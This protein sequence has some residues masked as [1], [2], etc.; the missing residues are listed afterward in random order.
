MQK[1]GAQII[2]NVKAVLLPYF[3]RSERTFLQ[4]YNEQVSIPRGGECFIESRKDLNIL[5][6]GKE[7]A[8]FYV[9]RSLKV[10]LPLKVRTEV[11]KQ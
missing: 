3:S 1:A 8:E 2:S 11:Q 4:K 9:K 10:H 5:R 7:K 6:K